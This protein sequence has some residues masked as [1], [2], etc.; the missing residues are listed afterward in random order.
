MA[1]HFSG[2][3][4]DDFKL[5]NNAIS[6]TAIGFGN[7]YKVASSCPDVVP[8]VD[9]QCGSSDGKDEVLSKGLTMEFIF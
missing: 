9:F 5:L 2:I 3:T 4:T 6:P 1:G 8:K 7:S